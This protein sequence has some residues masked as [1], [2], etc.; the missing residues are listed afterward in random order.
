M[1]RKLK[2]LLIN[3]TAPEWRVK[4][5]G[6]PDDSTKP[7]RF[8]MLSSL[9]VAAAM[10]HYVETKIVDEDIEQ[11]DFN[12]DA[13]LVGISF[14]TFNAPRAY[15]IA[16]RFRAAGKK[17]IVGGYHPTFMPEEAALHSD[18]VCVGEA[19]ANVPKM[20]ED[21]VGGEM[22]GIYRHELPDLKGLPV[23]DRSLVR[24]N[25]Y[26][27]ADTAQATR[28]CPNACRFCSI[29]A[30]FKH[31]FRTR[32]VDEVIE[33]LSGLGRYIMFMDDSIVYDREYATELFSRMVPLRKRW[34]SQCTVDI[35][36]DD[37]LLE[38]AHESGCGGLFVGL[39]SLSQDSLRTLGKNFN[40]A[41]D[42]RKSVAALHRA[43]IA[44]FAGIVFGNDYDTPDVFKNTVEFLLKANVDALQATIM[45]PFPGTPLH[46]ELKKQGRIT[47]TDWARYNFGNVVFEP[48]NMSAGALKRGHDWVLSQFYSRSSIARRFYREL[49]YMALPVMAHGTIPL[50]LGYRVRLAKVAGLRD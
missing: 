43:G 46:D 19:E 35:A 41:S 1:N 42:Y 34:F 15:E 4:G 23:P 49:G 21:F 50:N 37:R 2:F 45:T 6:R 26:V 30:F 48:K 13:D 33:E 11:I 29:T 40:R 32:P 17:V 28:G 36:N 8:S 47:C 10:P 39:E 44:V 31:R 22:S 38:L 5:A 20:M 3:P 9:Y 7:F 24:R 25:F 16:D 27:R 12:T 18:A 14:M